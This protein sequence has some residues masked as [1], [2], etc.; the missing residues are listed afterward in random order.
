MQ[1]EVAPRRLLLLNAH[2]STEKQ[3][4]SFAPLRCSYVASNSYSFGSTISTWGSPSRSSPIAAA[5][6]GVGCDS[7]RMERLEL[8]VPGPH[9][10]LALGSWSG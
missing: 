5:V 9:A 7:E 4:R 8:L 1:M 6:W 3:E 10:I 2:E